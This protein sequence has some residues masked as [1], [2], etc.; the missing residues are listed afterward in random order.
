M[1]FP[2]LILLAGFCIIEL[3][4]LFYAKTLAI[5]WLIALLCFYFK[6]EVFHNL[7]DYLFDPA[8]WLF[9]LFQSMCKIVA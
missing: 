4:L 5:I 7:W 1:D 6:L 3:Y 9:C 2:N 8:L